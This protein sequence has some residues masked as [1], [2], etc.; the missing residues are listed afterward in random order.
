MTMLPVASTMTRASGAASSRR[1]NSLFGLG[2]RRTI[3]LSLENNMERLPIALS[4]GQGARP[5]RSRSGPRGQ[6]LSVVPRP[7]RVSEERVPRSLPGNPVMVRIPNC[8]GMSHFL[9]GRFNPSRASCS[10]QAI[11]PSKGQLICSSLLLEP[12]MLFNFLELAGRE[13]FV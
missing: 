4:T 3:H 9:P 1:S 8:S 11:A 2:F 10:I 13:G 6:P 5:A 12:G 7:T